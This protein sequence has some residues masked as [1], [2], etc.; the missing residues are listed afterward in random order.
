MLA[1]GAAYTISSK[2]Q[3]TKRA[4]IMRILRRIDVLTICDR[5]VRVYA[6]QTNWRDWSQCNWIMIGKKRWW[7]SLQPLVCVAKSNQEAVDE[8]LWTTISLKSCRNFFKTDSLYK[9]S[10]SISNTNTDECSVWKRDGRYFSEILISFWQFSHK[11]IIFDSKVLAISRGG[12]CYL[13]SKQL[14]EH[15]LFENQQNNF[16]EDGLHKYNFLV[17]DPV[18]L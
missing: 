1:N 14:L 12:F 8:N 15:F 17:P 7:C 6:S 4:M 13:C 9:Q 16:S 5:T 11:I 3:A 2:L 18:I 10:R